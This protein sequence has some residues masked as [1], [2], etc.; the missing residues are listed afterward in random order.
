MGAGTA[1]TALAD[2]DVFVSYSTAFETG[3]K[4]ACCHHIND[5]DCL[6]RVALQDLILLFLQYTAQRHA[7]DVR[8]LTVESA[9]RAWLAYVT[10]V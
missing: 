9:E 1:S 2:A 7:A 10:V 4:T 5:D 3:I 8:E 6:P